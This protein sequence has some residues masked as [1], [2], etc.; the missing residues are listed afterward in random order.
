MID[1]GCST[2]HPRTDK[3]IKNEESRRIF[4]YQSNGGEV[5]GSGEIYGVKSYLDVL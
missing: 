1:E 3:E 2:P 4:D 5:F